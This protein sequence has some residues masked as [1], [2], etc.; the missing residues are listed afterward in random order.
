MRRPGW[1]RG[2]AKPGRK[3]SQLETG[4]G[5]SLL[6]SLEHD[7]CHTAGTAG[8]SQDWLSLPPCQSFTGR[9]LWVVQEVGRGT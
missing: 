7:L 5:L 4:F 2:R 8:R 9:R 6:G 1:G 3:C